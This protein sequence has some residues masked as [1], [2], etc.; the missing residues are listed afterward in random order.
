[1]DMDFNTK[2]AQ[3][4]QEIS[5]KI[6]L[7]EKSLLLQAEF[8]LHQSQSPIFAYFMK[9]FF[10]LNGA[11]ESQFYVG[12]FQSKRTLKNFRAET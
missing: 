10:F 5:A 1:M 8:N 11:V 3:Y 12:F 7:K 9:S 6:Y 2:V 4:L